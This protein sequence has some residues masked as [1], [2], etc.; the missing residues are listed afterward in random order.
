MNNN[1]KT[2]CEKQL[3]IDKFVLGL[4]RTKYKKT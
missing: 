3:Q 2:R 4:Q 1:E